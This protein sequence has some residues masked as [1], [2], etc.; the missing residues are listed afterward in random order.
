M[1]YGTEPNLPG[2]SNRPFLEPLTEEDPEL[3]AD[4]TLDRIRMLREKRLQANEDMRQQALKD[5]KRWD[6]L[7]KGGVTQVFDINDY[8]MLRHESKRGLEFN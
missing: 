3:I 1:T 2:D 6:E 4:D 8:V 5:K 7:V